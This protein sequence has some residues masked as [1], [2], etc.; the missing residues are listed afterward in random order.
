MLLKFFT[1]L[2]NAKNVPGKKGFSKEILIQRFLKNAAY[3]KDLHLEISLIKEVHAMKS[4]RYSINSCLAR[5]VEYNKK[6]F[7]GRI[8]KK[9]N[10]ISFRRY[11][12]SRFIN[13]VALEV[14]KMVRPSKAFAFP[15]SLHIDIGNICNS[16]CQ[17]CPT[18]LNYKHSLGYMSFDKFKQII[19]RI[20]RKVFIVGLHC[21]GE[22]MLHNDIVKMVNY[23]KQSSIKA[24]TSTNLHK[25]DEVVYRGLFDAGLRELI[26]SLHGI[27]QSSYDAYRPGFDFEKTLAN[28][29]KVV[30]LKEE[31]GAF[32]TEIKVGF[33][34]SK[35]NEHEVPL[36][37]E[38]CISHNIDKLAIYPASLNLR[39]LLKDKDLND[40]DVKKEERI[41]IIRNHM[42]K[43]QAKNPAYV[44]P[45]HRTI[46]EDPEILVSNKLIQK[47]WDPWY[48]IY[49][50][51][52]GNITPCCG[53]YDYNKDSL[54]NVFET[55][56]FKIWNNENYINS[57]LH[58]KN[59]PCK[60]NIL[61][62]KCIGG[63]Y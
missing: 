5:T 30:R 50:N 38:F 39:F 42:D 33:A 48:V 62:A 4:N 63:S 51:W 27:S 37:D 59:K 34:I 15:R 56:I 44:R 32:N 9:C 54:G 11:A 53:S 58:L 17:L 19:D 61:C 47:C 46:Y 26:V 43:W 40:L 6:G 36:L 2:F 35:F 20:K 49:I 16:N 8:K 52:E 57:R 3:C 45:I 41:N 18:G 60:D 55:D 25:Y 31:M 28:L 1:C 23:C 13:L 14:Q 22:P 21:W 7:W 29:N 24:V 12:F 10:R